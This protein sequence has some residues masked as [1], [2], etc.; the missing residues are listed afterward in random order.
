MVMNEVNELLSN[1][2]VVWRPAQQSQ[3]AFSTLQIRGGIELR[4][5]DQKLPFQSFK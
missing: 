4:S 3:A 5:L 2:P 1:N